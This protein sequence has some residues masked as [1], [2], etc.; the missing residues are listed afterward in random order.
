MSTSCE[1]KYKVNYYIITVLTCFNELI[2]S[3]LFY[4]WNYNH[5]EFKVLELTIKHA[6]GI[7]LFQGSHHPA[8]R[9]QGQANRS[10]IFFSFLVAIVCRPLCDAG[11]L[12][13]NPS[14]YRCKSGRLF[15]FKESIYFPEALAF[16][17]NAPRRPGPPAP[18]RLRPSE[19]NG[20]KT[21]SSSSKFT[22][23]TSLKLIASSILYTKN[24]GSVRLLYSPEAVFL[25][26]I[27]TKVFRLFLLAILSLP[28][29]IPLEQKSFTLYTK[30]SSL[31]SQDYVQKPQG[32]CT[33]MNSASCLFF[34]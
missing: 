28:T 26:V 5:C 33:F 4:R 29:P 27:G 24:G 9:E 8:R 23:S 30:T 32:N 25:N 16:L 1:E 20:S 21:S 15:L 19:A 7:Q 12:D 2:P 17:S 18:G 6:E 10:N 22:P 14:C 34:A 11:W 31:N 3:Y 13:S